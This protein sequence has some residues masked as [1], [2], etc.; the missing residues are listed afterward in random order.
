[1]RKVPEL[2]M[3][4]G[5]N[6]SHEAWRHRLRSGSAQALMARDISRLDG[7]RAIGNFAD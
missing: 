7:E 2:F 1:M 6:P 3:K 5:N 4:M